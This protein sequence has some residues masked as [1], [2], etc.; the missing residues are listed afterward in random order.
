MKKDVFCFGNACGV[1]FSHL[2]QTRGMDKDQ[3]YTG[4]LKEEK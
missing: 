2:A 3:F 1:Y 4:K